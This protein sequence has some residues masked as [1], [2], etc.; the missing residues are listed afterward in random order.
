MRGVKVAEAGHDRVP[1][2]ILKKYK[3]MFGKGLTKCYTND[4]IE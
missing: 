3:Q 4:K 2:A 1:W